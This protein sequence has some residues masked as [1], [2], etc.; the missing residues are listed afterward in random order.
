[1][2][3]DHPIVCV[4]VC[5]GGGGGGGGVGGGGGRDDRSVDRDGDPVKTRESSWLLILSKKKCSG[6][7]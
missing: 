1:M 2:F 6:C 3:M 7:L 4:C 5:V